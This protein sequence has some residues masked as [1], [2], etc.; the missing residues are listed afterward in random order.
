MR[1]NRF[2]LTIAAGFMTMAAYAQTV[3]EIVDKH[4]AALGG[5]DKIKA[6]TTIVADRSLAVNGMD[7]P[8]KTVLVVGKSVRNESTA[9]G[10][11]MLQVLDGDKGWMVRPVQF[12]G[13]GE[14]EDLPVDQ[15]KQLAGS[16]DPFGGLVNYKE[17][18]SAVELVGKEKVDKKDVF[19]LKLTSKEGLVV[20]QF[21]DANTYLINKTKVAIA[22]QEGQIDFSDYKEVEGVK[23]PYTMDIANSQMSMSFITNKLTVN[24]QVDEAIFKRPVK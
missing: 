12:G 9:M 7:I 4:V 11:T 24:S 17:K 14:P 22:G 19:H 23:M 8:T 2:L 20:D 15:L 1:T 5:I 13:T 10:N 18:G 16:L 21:V 6:I 3:D